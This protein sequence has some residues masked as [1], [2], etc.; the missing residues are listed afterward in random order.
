MQPENLRCV[1]V[2][3]HAKAGEF[4][5]F[6]KRCDHKETTID[7]CVLATRCLEDFSDAIDPFGEGRSF[8][9]I[10]STPGI[11]PPLR[12]VSDFKEFVG[13]TVEV[14]LEEKRDGRKKAKGQL[15]EINDKG[16]LQVMTSRGIWS[17]P[18]ESIIRARG[19][20]E[21]R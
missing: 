21:S 10:V 3:I 16:L 11:D 19:F 13:G 2:D 4:V 15:T 8:D 7:D 6:I 20:S 9:F 17:A 14:E 12:D 18:I 1:D 5:V